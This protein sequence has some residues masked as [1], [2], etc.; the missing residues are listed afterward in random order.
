MLTGSPPE[1]W[2]YVEVGNSAAESARENRALCDPIAPFISLN[3]TPF[4]ASSLVASACFSNS[5]RCPSCRKS[6]Y[7]S[8]GKNAASRYTPSRLK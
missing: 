8:L 2:W 6:S 4:S 7:D 3:T 5:R 1:L